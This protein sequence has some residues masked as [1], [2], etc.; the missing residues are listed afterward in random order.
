M[1]E[2]QSQSVNGQSEHKEDYIQVYLELSSLIS[3]LS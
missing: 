2:K 3:H 1:N